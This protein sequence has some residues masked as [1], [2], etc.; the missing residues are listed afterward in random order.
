MSRPKINPETCEK[1]CPT[2]LKNFTIAYVLRNRRTYCSKQCSNNSPEIIEKKKLAQQNTFQQKYGMH[3]MKTEKTKDNLRK[4]IKQKYGV[5]WISSSGG[6]YEKVKK[7]N[8]IKYG[9]EHYNNSEQSKKTCIE[10]YGV[11]NPTK[12]KIII[13]N[14]SE[15]KRKNHYEYLKNFSKTNNLEMLFSYENYSGYHFSNIYKF[16]CCKCNYIFENSV[17]NLNSLFCE[18]CD[19]DK[20]KT[21]ENSFFEFLSSLTPSL[22]ITRRDRTILYG[23]ELDFYL[24]EKKIAFELNGLYWH[25]ENGTGILEN[26]HLNKTKGCIAHGVRLIHIFEN[27]WRDKQEL[28]KSIIKTILK[29]Q[30]TN[31][32]YARSCEIKEVPIKEK[33]EFLNFNHLQQEDK[34]TIKLG[35][36]SDNKLISLMTFRNKSRFDTTVEWELSR[37]CNLKDTIV[38]GGA[39]KLF[40]YFIK[41]YSPKSIVSYSDRRY[42]SGDL[43]HILGFSF[44]ANTPPSYHYIT[45]DYKNTVNR[46]NFQKHLLSKKLKTFNSE[47]TEWDNMKNNGWDRIWDCGNGKWIWKEVTQAVDLIKS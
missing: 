20:K 47:L 27:E 43:Y 24:P 44:V 38:V 19:P 11:D 12:S 22:L 45:P 31:I 21:L 32:F 18:K 30:V 26:Y 9:V 25:S 2:C 34:S 29:L 33:N 46:M 7:N 28:V 6:W 42:F 5:D 37:F 13:D 36:Y 10:R 3:P 23:K 17:Y 14:I 16:K 8:L 15:T 35:L 39:S 40:S 41:T 1:T 4:S